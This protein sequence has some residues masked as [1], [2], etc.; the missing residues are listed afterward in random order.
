MIPQLILI[1]FMMFNIVINTIKHGEDKKQEYNIW[2][3]IIAVIINIIILYC[4]GFW[5]VLNK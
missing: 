4:G 2:T 1:F 5:D 3:T